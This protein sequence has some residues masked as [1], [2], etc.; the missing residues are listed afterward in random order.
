MPRAKR[1]KP[2]ADYSVELKE[3]Q[4]HFLRAQEEAL[5]GLVGLLDLF[6]QILESR[7]GQKRYESLLRTMNSL[8]ALLRTVIGVL[9]L[10][11]RVGK[12]S[13]KPSRPARSTDMP[14]ARS[15]RKSKI[16]KITIA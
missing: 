11:T 12:S 8:E 5:K 7:E 1:Q 16:S 3:I 14:G 13:R 6:G 10:D 4:D 2:E 9:A 15:H